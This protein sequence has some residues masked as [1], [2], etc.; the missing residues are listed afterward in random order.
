MKKNRLPGFSCHSRR[1]VAEFR[2]VVSGTGANQHRRLRVSAETRDE[3]LS[4]RPA[5]PD[6]G[7]GIIGISPRTSF[8]ALAASRS[9][10]IL[11]TLGCFLCSL[12]FRHSASAP[13]QLESGEADAALLNFGG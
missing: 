5:R 11:R 13:P 10:R 6:L 7:I 9:Y 12:T 8:E 4:T 3:A 1:K 2:V